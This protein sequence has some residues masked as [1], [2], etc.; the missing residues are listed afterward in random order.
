M[1]L[2]SA[3]RLRESPV[4]CERWAREPATASLADLEDT[5]QDRYSAF[6]R[7][8]GIESAQQTFERATDLLLRYQLFPPDLVQATVCTPDGR[9]VPGAVVAQRT[10]MGPFGVESAV[11][12]EEVIDDEPTYA[13]RRAAIS[14]VTLRGHPLVGVETVALLMHE[15]GRLELNFTSTSRPA[16]LLTRLAWPIARR[17]QLRATRRAQAHFRML[18]AQTGEEYVPPPP[19]KRRP[20]LEAIGAVPV[21]P[22]APA[23]AE[24]NG[25]ASDSGEQPSTPTDG[26]TPPPA[27]ETPPVDTSPALE[28]PAA[29]PPAS[30]S[31]PAASPP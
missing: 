29:P 3:R 23:T 1:R 17:L 28:R 14:L 9:M 25:P 20:A 4:E 6:I 7:G 18:V 22:L 13:G 30:G 26:E 11:R 27:A 31:P 8:T 12:I 24:A 21:D 2:T 10:F 5:R 19:R 15:T 16:G